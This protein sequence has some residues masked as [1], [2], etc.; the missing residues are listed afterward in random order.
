[1]TDELKLILDE[2]QDL[3]SKAINHLEAELVKSDWF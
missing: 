2:G 3:M 1:M